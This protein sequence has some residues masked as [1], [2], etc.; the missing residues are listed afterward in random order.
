MLLEVEPPLRRALGPV[1]SELREL[2]KPKPMGQRPVTLDFIGPQGPWAIGPLA[3]DQGLWPW[4][5]PK[6]NLGG[7]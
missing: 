6:I 7:T 1:K 3:Q 4:V 2:I 5:W